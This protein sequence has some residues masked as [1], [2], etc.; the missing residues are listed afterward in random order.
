[1]KRKLALILTFIF[2]FTAALPLQAFGAGIDSGLEN[3]IKVAR[4][5]F[6]IPDNYKFDSNIDSDGVKNIFFLNWRNNNGT[7]YSYISVRVD[8][9]GTVLSYDKYKPSDYNQTRKLPRV[10]RQE[11]KV[12]AEAF[13]KKVNPALSSQ[14]RYEDDNR[15]TLLDSMYYF[16]FYRVVNGIP[17]Y[18]DRV[19]VVVSRETGDIQSFYTNWTDNLVFPA[20]GKQITLEQAEDAYKANLGLRMIYKY[21]YTDDKL[22][23]YLV[24][25]PRYDNDSY[26]VDAF[27]GEKVKVGNTYYPYYDAVG[28]GEKSMA[29]ATTQ[30]QVVLNPEELKAVQDAAKLKTS[31]EAEKI[32]RNARFLELTDK[33]ELTNYNLSPSWPAR[34]EYIW[35]LNFNKPAADKNSI[36][37]YASVSV[38][39][40]TGM[41][42]SFYRG[43][44]HKEGDVAKYDAAKAKSAVDAFVKE[45][46][47]GL[48][49]QMEYDADYEGNFIKYAGVDAPQ[50]Y[51]FKYNRLVNGIAFPDNGITV[52]YDAVSGKVSSL[53]V[54]WFNAEF[55]AADGVITVD[56]AYAK[57]FE[58]VGMDLQYKTDNSVLKPFVMGTPPPTPEVKLVYSFKPGKPL[59]FDVNSGVILDGN[60]SPYKE[61]KPVTY[62]DIKGSFAEEQIM[63]L[64]ENGV[65]LDGTEFKPETEI[66]QKDFFTL[67]SRTLNYYGT[68]ITAN[69][70][71]KDI[72]ELYAFLE[73]EGI[74]K[75]G[76]KAPDS[77]VTR[78]DAVKY[79]I[80]ALK[81]DKVADIKGIFTVSFKDQNTAQPGLS[82]YITVAAGLKIIGGFDGNFYP[83]AKLTRE[84]AAVMIYNY[85]QV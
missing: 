20:L 43:T 29:N 21:S 28:M 46:Y 19:N 70:T 44:P 6:D 72:D 80:R 17:Y 65:Y 52:E 9:K 56:A 73:R 11:A 18:N 32:A 30:G 38:N 51:S 57:A 8:D 68:A 76:E 7:D 42:V 5:L 59:V 10:S 64:A 35:Y 75:A 27:T 58:A 23:T 84:A 49:A 16:N 33:F 77:L 85:L 15:N 24:Y 55:P 50:S 61:V 71:Q 40:N 3:A 37:E 34:D 4:S 63:V 78:E 25:T 48:Y 26:A 53:S 62:T 13:I 67:L 66:T 47:P 81:Y 12:K 41:I 60:G 79:I 22:K 1:M 82:G 31:A 45:N 74:V 69:S 36:S 39:A 2:A 14:I 83:K 54:N